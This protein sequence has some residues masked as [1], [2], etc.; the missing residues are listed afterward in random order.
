MRKIPLKFRLVAAGFYVILAMV[1][2]SMP[3]AAIPILG[4]VWTNTKTIHPL[5]DRSGRDSFNY[6]LNHSLS[7]LIFVSFFVILSITCP[8]N[9]QDQSFDNFILSTFG[10]IQATY[11]I[12]SIIAGIFALRGYSFNNRL[13]YPF[14]IDE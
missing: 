2:I 5:L 3:F 10:L 12:S 7:M 8:I 1:S 4:L 11:F 6:A 14:V 9:C 13:I